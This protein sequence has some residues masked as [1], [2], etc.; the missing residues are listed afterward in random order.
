MWTTRSI[1]NDARLDDLDGRVAELS[2]RVDRLS[3]RID[4]LQRAMVQ[5]VVAV[6]AVMVTGFLGLAGMIATQL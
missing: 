4:G 3:H 5:A 6:T 1:W 2:E